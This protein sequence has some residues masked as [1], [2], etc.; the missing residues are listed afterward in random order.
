MTAV[1][2]VLIKAI[3]NGG[4]G[5]GLEIVVVPLTALSI[6]PPHA[7]AIMLPILILRDIHALWNFPY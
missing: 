1:P 2:G 6:S 7:A 4:L 5:G 3:A